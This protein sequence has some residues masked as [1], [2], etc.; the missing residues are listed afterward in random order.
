MAATEHTVVVVNHP[1]M[2]TDPRLHPARRPLFHQVRV[3]GAR[4][5][6]ARDRVKI[7]ARPLGNMA[8]TVS[9]K[10]GFTCYQGNLF[11]R[12]ASIEQFEASLKQS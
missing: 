1:G 11:G 4:V 6:V 3:L 2:H 8:T 5:L 10:N 9:S 7:E 12:R